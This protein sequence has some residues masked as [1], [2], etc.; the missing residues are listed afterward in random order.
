MMYHLAVYN[1]LVNSTH[2]IKFPHRIFSS[3][4]KNS[5]IHATFMI[6]DL[7]TMYHIHDS[8]IQ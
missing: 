7:L 8:V 1:V 3:V 4:L 6:D 5:L 2:L